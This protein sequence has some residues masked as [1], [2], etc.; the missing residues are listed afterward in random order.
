VG[1]HLLTIFKK[2][3]EYRNS[4]FIRELPESIMNYKLD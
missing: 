2:Q 1:L 4:Y 3:F